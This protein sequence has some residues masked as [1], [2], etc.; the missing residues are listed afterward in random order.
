MDGASASC[1]ALFGLEDAGGKG[2]D[3]GVAGAAELA[4][5]LAD[6]EAVPCCLCV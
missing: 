1:G 2:A 4:K 5:P 3:S 6:E